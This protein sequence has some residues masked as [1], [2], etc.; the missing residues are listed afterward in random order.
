MSQIM[1]RVLFLCSGNYY[2]SRFAERLFNWLADEGGLPWQ[3]ESRG[4][5]VGYWG[6][7]GPI[8]DFAVEAWQRLGIPV[9]QQHRHPEP[10]TLADLTRADLIIAVKEAEHRAMIVEQFPLWENRVEYWNVD[11][12][13]CA[14]PRPRYPAWNRWFGSWHRACT[15]RRGSTI[16]GSVIPCPGS[17][18]ANENGRRTRPWLN[19]DFYR[20][21]S[22][23]P[24][25]RP[26][27]A[28]VPDARP[29]AV[30]NRPRRPVKR[31]TA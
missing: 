14:R 20:S 1:K 19:L 18:P 12:L 2:R 10:L 29:A 6:N 15:P 22:T 7:I 16:R 3:A 13:D 28:S 17:A 9:P 24:L 27:R 11:D 31:G 23:G 21:A 8:S 4:L 30:W 26:G 5:K 25:F